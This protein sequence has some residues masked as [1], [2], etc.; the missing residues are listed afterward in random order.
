MPTL[1]RMSIYDKAADKYTLRINLPV[2]F[3]QMLVDALGE[4]TR[5]S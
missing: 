1:I 4:V 5:S 3:A 2:A